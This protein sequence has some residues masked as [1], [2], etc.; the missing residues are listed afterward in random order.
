PGVG[1]Y[2][3]VG[4][5]LAIDAVDNQLLLPREIAH[6]SP[7]LCDALVVGNTNRE[8]RPGGGLIVPR[9]ALLLT[10]LE[11]HLQAIRELVARDDAN[12]AEKR[13]RFAQ[14]PGARVGDN[15]EHDLLA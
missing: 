11:A 8:R 12:I 9:Q 15:R 14:P 10:V 6:R 4:L 2:R 1:A 5:A 7:N 13:L 3:L